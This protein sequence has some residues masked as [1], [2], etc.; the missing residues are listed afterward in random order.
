[1]IFIKNENGFRIVKNV[2]Y[3]I[4][5]ICKENSGFTL[6][7]IMV[8]AG[9]LGGL[10]L[11]VMELTSNSAKSAKKLQQDFEIS[12]VMSNVVNVLRDEKSCSRNFNADY[13]GGGLGTYSAGNVS[14]TDG[15]PIGDQILKWDAQLSSSYIIVNQG[16]TYG[17]LQST[18]IELTSI[19][20][21]DNNAVTAS[22]AGTVPALFTRPVILQFLFTRFCLYRY[23]K[24][25]D[26]TAMN[27]ICIF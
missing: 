8:A 11:A 17:S 13:S 2:V 20:F 19:N 12:N 21:R 6:V 18:K 3:F 27:T 7:E 16:D 5:K 23:C 14:S 24:F 22:V 15:S 26:T 9:L 10:S 25:L 1:M 4:K